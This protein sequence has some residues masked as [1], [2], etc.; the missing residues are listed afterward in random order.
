MKRHYYANLLLFYLT[1]ATLSIVTFIIVDKVVSHDGL[2]FF[3]TFFISILLAFVLSYIYSSSLGKRFERLSDFTDSIKKGNF[4]KYITPV[5]EDAIGLVEKSLA[6]MAGEIKNA[7]EKL[8]DEVGQRESVLSSMGE[9][10][11]VIDQSDT[12]T[13]SNK[14]GRDLFGGILTGKKISLLSR[15]PMLLNLIEEGKKKWTTVNGEILISEPREMI[16]FLT[17]SPLIRNMKTHGSVILFR[18]VTMLKKLENMRKDFVVNVSHELKTP[19]TSI[20]GFAETLIDGGI[21]D[22]ENALRFLG[23][24]KN[25]SERLSRLVEDLLTISNIEMGKVTLHN[26]KVNVMSAIEAAKTILDS[27]AQAKELYLKVSGENSLSAMAD[28]D[29]LEQI[30]INLI[31]NGLKFTDKGGITVSASEKGEVISFTVSD[32]GSGI[33]KKDL[34]RLGERFYRVDS[35]RSRD[36]GGTGLGLAIVKH[37][38]SSMGGTLDFDSEVGK[39]TTIGFTLPKG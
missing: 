27:K 3:L 9:A 6:T 32:T 7:L 8:E 22:K 36:L 11:L 10:V 31:D 33:P 21:D 15:D 13:L 23:I 39:G 29:R 4:D 18:D 5:S 12:I 2:V 38:V 37:L 19:L 14:K 17:I 16:L 34:A 25:N 30:L 24:I 20:R 28:K 26:K 1:A 35:A